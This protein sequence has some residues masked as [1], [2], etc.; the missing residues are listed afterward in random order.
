MY[1]ALKFVT[2][3]TAR[4]NETTLPLPLSTNQ[5]AA[6]IIW[7]EINEIENAAHRHVM[8]CIPHLIRLLIPGRFRLNV[9]DG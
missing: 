9:L 8:P 7:S 2:S 6:W 5:N 4:R 1:K 3:P